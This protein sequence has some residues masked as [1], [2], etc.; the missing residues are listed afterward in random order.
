MEVDYPK[1]EGWM[2]D[3][4]VRGVKLEESE[5]LRWEGETGRGESLNQKKLDLGTVFHTERHSCTERC[6][7]EKRLLV[8]KSFK[9]S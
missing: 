8:P 7:S 1:E 6:P 5:Y 4:K 2:N 3:E 9:R